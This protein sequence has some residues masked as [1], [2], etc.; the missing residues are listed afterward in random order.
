MAG[1]HEISK[2]GNTKALELF[3]RVIELD[4]DFAAAHGMAAWCYSTGKV[5]GWIIFD[6]Q[7]IAEARRLA[8]RAVE[9]GKDDAIA[10]CAGGFALAF[11]AGETDRAVIFIDRALA[12]NS[13]L[14]MAWFASGWVR[15]FFGEPEIAIQH[16]ASAMRLSPL[17]PRLYSMQTGTGFA[18]FLAGRYE[19]ALSW[20][21]K[22]LR[23]QADWLAAIRLM[24]A[25]Y[26]L[27]GRVA[28]AQKAMTHMLEIDPLRR[29]SN[30]KDISG[31]FRSEDLS[32]YEEALRRAG[33]PD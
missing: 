12:L 6:Q 17:D 21:E 29:I 8:Q 32:R 15:V 4:P 24:A 33:L 16:L 23:A 3:Y 19:E 5:Q 1:F 13:N 30:L 11:A 2:K 18:H 10:L 7:V 14:A 20:S 22:A 31:P 26:A 9:L 28:E 27:G 25:S